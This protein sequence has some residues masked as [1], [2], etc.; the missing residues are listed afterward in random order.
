MG[1]PHLPWGSLN[2]RSS[3]VRLASLS[4]S[5]VAPRTLPSF[6]DLLLFLPSPTSPPSS[7]PSLFFLRRGLSARFFFFLGSSPSPAARFRLCTPICLTVSSSMARSSMAMLL[8]SKSP[9]CSSSCSSSSA[10][11]STDSLSDN[12]ASSTSSWSGISSLSSVTSMSWYGS[13]FGGSRTEFS[14]SIS[15]RSGSAGSLPAS[16]SGELEC[17][18]VNSTSSMVGGVRKGDVMCELG[19]AGAGVVAQTRNV[20]ILDICAVGRP[21]RRR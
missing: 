21:Y 16:G 9:N 11:D 8:A 18:L 12:P 19:G 2:I 14:S 13:A 20:S 5:G 7:S 3:G 15:G 17:D 10:S 4:T 1:H 6:L